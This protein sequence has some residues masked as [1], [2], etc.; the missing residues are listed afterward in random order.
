[1]GQASRGDPLIPGHRMGRAS[2]GPRRKLWCSC[3]WKWEQ[4]DP[5]MALDDARRLERDHEL[6]HRAL[7]CPPLPAE[8]DHGWVRDR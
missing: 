5:G 8:E 3:G 4:P 6:A 2:I 7:A 1:M